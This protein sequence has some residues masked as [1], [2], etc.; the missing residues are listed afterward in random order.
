ML[1]TPWLLCVSI[2]HK[3]ITPKVI[4]KAGLLWYIARGN[5]S[6]SFPS[7][8]HP[9]F[10]SKTMTLRESQGGGKEKRQLFQK[11]KKK[12][13]RGTWVVQSVKHQTLDFVSGHDLKAH[14]ISGSAL[15]AQRLTGILPL[16]PS[17][18]APSLLTLS[19]KINK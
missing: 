12:S 11:K 19:L 18:S 16:S 10:G 6:N 7:P 2:T 3:G 17:L 4:D 13:H 14:D 15:A 1:R 5:H 9:A 8:S